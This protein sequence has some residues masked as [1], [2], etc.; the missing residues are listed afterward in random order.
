MSKSK[1]FLDEIIYKSISKK[2]NFQKLQY[3]MFFARKKVITSWV[4]TVVNTGKLYSCSY[5][6]YLIG[7]IDMM[8]VALQ[9]LQGI[10]N[11]KEILLT[12]SR[13]FLHSRHG[14]ANCTSLEMEPKYPTKSDVQLKTNISRTKMIEGYCKKH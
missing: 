6:W 7:V 1:S 13:Y 3:Q 12:V 9:G 10:V 2:I 4:K 11:G 8:H 14:W 5:T